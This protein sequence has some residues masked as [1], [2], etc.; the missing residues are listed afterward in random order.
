MK[1]PPLCHT[2][3]YFLGQQYYLLDTY[4]LR[5]NKCLDANLC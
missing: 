5:P 3:E 2:F 4:N 1:I